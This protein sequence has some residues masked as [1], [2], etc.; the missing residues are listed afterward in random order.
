MGVNIFLENL[1]NFSV[2]ITQTLYFEPNYRE[3]FGVPNT[4]KPLHR[5][6]STTINIYPLHSV[7]TTFLFNYFINV[8]AYIYKPLIIAL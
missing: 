5:A 6:V 1:K 7:S 2:W 4:Y 3:L 8:C